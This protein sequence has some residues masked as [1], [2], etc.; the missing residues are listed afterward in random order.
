MEKY[1]E[2][3]YFEVAVRAFIGCALWSSTYSKYPTSG[4]DA[5]A[6]G[7][8]GLLDGDSLDIAFGY[9]DVP[10]AIREKARWA[11][12]TF[13]K[14]VD[15]ALGKDVLTDYESERGSY[16]NLFEKMRGRAGQIGYDLWL[17]SARHGA[18]FWEGR[19]DGYEDDGLK[20][21]EIARKYVGDDISLDIF[22]REEATEEARAASTADEFWELYGLFCDWPRIQHLT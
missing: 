4:D 10:D 20:L 21:T 12:A 7:P 5:G 16:N 2:H 3:R 15:E 11:V 6:V 22:S 17:T 19:V 14:H 9:E 13:M 1:K 18:G 8:R